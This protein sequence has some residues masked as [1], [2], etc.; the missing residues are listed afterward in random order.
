MFDADRLFDPYRNGFFCENCANEVTDNSQDE[1]D[2][3]GSGTLVC[4][5]LCSV[6][7]HFRHA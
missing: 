2:A 5:G 6:L 3:D 4:Y 7:D 1:G